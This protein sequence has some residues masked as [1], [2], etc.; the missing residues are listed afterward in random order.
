MRET[1]Q[2]RAMDDYFHSL[3]LD[4]V[5]LRED[6]DD[7]A[8]VPVLQMQPQPAD[9]DKTADRRDQKLDEAHQDEIEHG[10]RRNGEQP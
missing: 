4:D 8:P 10:Q 2:V 1:T 3:L 5:L 9:L 7:E 6:P